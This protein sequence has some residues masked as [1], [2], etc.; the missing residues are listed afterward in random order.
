MCVFFYRASFNVY[1]TVLTFLTS[2]ERIQTMVIY[3][4]RLICIH[5]HSLRSIGQYLYDIPEINRLHGNLATSCT[6]SV[7]TIKH[8]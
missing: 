4:T 2:V 7:I 5:I 6:T 1:K 3:G 8:E